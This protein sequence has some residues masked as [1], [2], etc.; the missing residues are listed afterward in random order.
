DDRLLDVHE[1]LDADLVVPEH[2]PHRTDGGRERRQGDVQRRRDDEHVDGDRTHDPESLR[3]EQR[4]DS[5]HRRH[6]LLGLGDGCNDD[7]DHQHHDH[8]ADHEH[9]DDHQAD[10]HHYVDGGAHD[11]H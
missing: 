11:H 10:D 7:L 2:D 9:H 5:D 1:R 4:P 8:Q 3:H 6:R